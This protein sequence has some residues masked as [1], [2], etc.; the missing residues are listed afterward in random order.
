ML[1][2][3][4]QLEFD[5]S[6]DDEI[7]I[8]LL[9]ESVKIKKLSGKK[10]EKIKEIIKSSIEFDFKWCIFKYRENNIDIEKKFDDVEDNMDKKQL[11][12]VITVNYTIPVIANFVYEHNKKNIDSIQCLLRD[13]VYTKIESYFIENQLDYGE[14][15]LICENQIFDN[16]HHL[17]FYELISKHKINNSFYNEHTKTNNIILAYPTSENLNDSNKIN[18]NDTKKTMVLPINEINEKKLC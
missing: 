10:S 16:F 3:V 18:I 11:K 8:V 4:Y 15:F 14:Y 6:Q 9:I 13:R 5:I 17:I 2:L 1:L 7:I 12:I